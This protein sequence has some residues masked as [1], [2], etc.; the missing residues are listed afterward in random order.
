MA[1]YHK[2][3]YQKNKEK[4]K[5][6]K[7]NKCECGNRKAK[8]STYCAKCYRGEKTKRWKGGRFIKDGYVFILLPTDSWHTKH[9][10]NYTLEHRMQIE[11][12]LGRNLIKGETVHH[13]NGDTQDNRIE[14]LEL[15]VSS[16]PG[17]QRVYDKI[18][19]AKQI[20]AQYGSD[21]EKY[22]NANKESKCD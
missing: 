7:Y 9:F 8:Y 1:N 13:K 18:I 2:E 20:L 14:N 5:A 17:G 10:D 4:L 16:H 22:L 12:E 6:Q 21:E 3:Y 19:W 11:K 15:W